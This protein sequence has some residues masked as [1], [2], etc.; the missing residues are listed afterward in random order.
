MSCGREVEACI[1]R[2]ERERE[3]E[4]ERKRERGRE[5]ER[6]RERERDLRGRDREKWGRKGTM[7]VA[8]MFN[9][10]AHN[11]AC[12]YCDEYPCT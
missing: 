11:N 3:R 4:R 10:V 8:L 2:R 9:G 6:E 5:R 1:V 12:V 7:V